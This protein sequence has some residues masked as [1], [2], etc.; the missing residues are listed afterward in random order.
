LADRGTPPAVAR[1]EFN[2]N[3]EVVNRFCDL[4]AAMKWDVQWF[5]YARV[6]T[7]DE[8]TI[9]RLARSGCRYL[10][11]GIE[12]G[13]PDLLRLYKDRYDRRRCRRPYKLAGGTA[14]QRWDISSSDCRER[15]P[16][17]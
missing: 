10:G 2:W 5:C 16:L 17:L 12:S 14:S 13:S 9:E 15:R 6:D 3:I 4:L 8:T 1:S 7:L 11:V